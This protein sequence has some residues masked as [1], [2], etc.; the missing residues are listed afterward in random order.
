MFL[1]KFIPSYR[2]ILH[3]LTIAA[4]ALSM[5]ACDRDYETIFGE[6]T[7]KRI[8]EALAEHQTLLTSA[9][10]G[11]RAMLYTGAGG[12]YFYHLQ[13]NED[14]NVTMFS[15][16]NETTAS[17]S[18]SSTW[19][20]KALQKITL[21]F[22]TYSYIHLPADPNGET[23]G[24][25]NGAGLLSDFEFTFVRTAGD[26]VIMKGLRY[27]N[28]L[29]LIKATAEEKIQIADDQ[30]NSILAATKTYATANT[31]LRLELPNGKV[32]P[33]RLE[34]AR[35]IFGAQ[36]L[37]A[38]NSQIVTFRT[39]FTISLDGVWLRDALQ[40]DGYS[41]HA[42]HWDADN[43]VYTAQLA[44]PV[45]LYNDIDPLIL[46][47]TTTLASVIGRDYKVIAIP[48]NPYENRIPGQS[49]NFVDIY[50][51]AAAELD[52][53]S[54]PIGLHEMFFVFDPIN[55]EMAYNVYLSQVQGGINQYPLIA[56]WVY[57]Y[58]ISAD[59]TLDLTAV[60]SNE[61]ANII[62]FEMRTMLQHLED[63]SFALHYIAGGFDLIGGL[64]SNENVDF[65]VAGILGN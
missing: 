27:A 47:P 51:M 55:Q 58:T 42:L 10:H 61:S 1:Y 22:D 57:S 43:G 7:D 39:P 23:S 45:A 62:S 15:D 41:I 59:G 37:S 54:T 6:S 29:V 64:Y 3:V 18:K 16:F 30:I 63:D 48:A 8:R 40:I 11:W 46:E 49:R 28:E 35:K 56:Q 60:R 24:G 50:D 19:V 53:R 33:I 4:A 17:T 38:D 21:T 12:G 9:P 32:L 52:Q 20:L 14:G 5:A 2:A 25:T 13:F 26:S 36:Y 31:G 34:V 65:T 44:T